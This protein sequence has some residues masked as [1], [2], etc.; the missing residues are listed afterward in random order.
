MSTGITIEFFYGCESMPR[1]KGSKNKPSRMVA[2]LV[3]HDHGA[4]GE[5]CRVMEALAA[6]LE[7]KLAER[8][9]LKLVREGKK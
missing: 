7:A 5:C 9:V 8:P 6:E 3:T 4:L 2:C 1:P